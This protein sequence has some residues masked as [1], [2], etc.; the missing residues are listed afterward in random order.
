MGKLATC[1]L[2]II[3][4]SGHLVSN[5]NSSVSSFCLH[6]LW[7]AHLMPFRSRNSHLYHLGGLLRD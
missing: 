2:C 5:D 6:F 3:L 4:I 1:T 7:P